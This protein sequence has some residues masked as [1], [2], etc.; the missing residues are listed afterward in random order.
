M[1]VA[2]LFN[3]KG[4]SM[5]FSEIAAVDIKDFRCLKE[6]HLDFTA[7]PIVCIQAGNDSGKSSA[8]KAI[9]TIM[10]NDNE[11]KNKNYIRTNCNSFTIAVTLKDGTR[12]ERIKGDSG[13]VYR[14]VAANGAITEW[15][16]LD[17][18]IPAQVQEIFGLVR[19]ETTGELLNIRTCESLLLFALTKASENHKIFYGQLKVD[20]VSNAMVCGKD[21]VNKLSTAIKAS[22]T[23]KENYLVRLRDIKVPDL[24]SVK[25]LKERIDESAKNMVAAKDI[26]NTMS[27]YN[28]IR[29]RMSESQAAISKLEAIPDSEIERFR[30]AEDILNDLNSCRQLQQQYDRVKYVADVQAVD[31]SQ[32][33][34]VSELEN[35][36][37]IVNQ[38]NELQK[39]NAGAVA[40]QIKDI[41]IIDAS[42]LAELNSINAIIEQKNALEQTLE[43]EK[44]T[45]ANL[46]EQ[47]DRSI[48]EGGLYFDS[49]DDSIVMKCEHCGEENRLKL[50]LIE[51][52]C[53]IVK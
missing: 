43:S 6:L 28:S 51:K 45:L 2:L 15:N 16:K 36:I 49:A 32:I 26:V 21:I 25:Q 10:Y 20:D 46:R 12:V 3:E 53:E 19:D 4:V 22:E 13:N 11:R 7:S 33:E 52:A 29:S 40:E 9:E 31:Y 34:L 5:S 30:R 35:T 42:M 17:N 48:K 1:R 47:L 14:I 18:D 23:T 37:A 8:V 27:E 39:S 44:Q 24:T 41:S 38:I 50:S